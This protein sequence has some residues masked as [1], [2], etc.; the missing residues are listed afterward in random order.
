VKNWSL[1]RRLVAAFALGAVLLSGGAAF[2][3]VTTGRL[4]DAEARV[5]GRLYD[6]TRASDDLLSAYLD[7][8]TGVRGYALSGDVQY[9]AP[10]ESGRA[11]QVVAQRNLAKALGPE[12]ALRADLRRFQDAADRWQSAFAEP[13]IASVRNAGRGSVSDADQARGKSLFDLVRQAFLTYQQQVHDDRAQAIRAMNRDRNALILALVA[14]GVLLVLGSIA[15]AAAL[16]VWV[17]RPLRIVRREVRTVV[18]GDLGH[19]VVVQ[20]PPELRALSVDVDGMR[21]RLVEHYQDAVQAQ[22][23]AESARSRFEAQGVELA[24]SNAELEQFAYVASHDLQEPLRKVASFTEI[25]QRRYAG[26]L[27]ERADQYIEFAVD[28]AK[29]MQRLINDLLAFSRVRRSIPNFLSVD[30]EEAYQLAVRNLELAIEESGASVTHEAL[31]VVVGEAS[32]LTQVLQ[33]LIGN[34]IKFRRPGVAPTVHVGVRRIG[35]L[36]EISVEDNG[37]G[38]SEEYAERVFVLFQR[39][40]RKEEYEGTGIGLALA[41]K[42]VEYHGGGITLSSDVGSGTTISFTLPVPGSVAAVAAATSTTH[43]AAPATIQ[44]PV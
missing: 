2:V 6:V 35:E 37:I 44:E 24:R 15:L 13:A 19:S 3:G 33:N 21:G 20:G 9:L 28:G 41:K 27:D 39:L 22:V 1:T 38:I 8:E 18:R 43:P 34:G 36:F 40:H 17:V 7:Q 42:I 26:Q 11:D 4:A 5:T 10:Y 31:P 30:L 32:L 14:A 16:R 23:A 12:P 25:L 29:R